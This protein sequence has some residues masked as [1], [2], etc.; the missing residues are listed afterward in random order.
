MTEETTS[1]ENANT[2]TLEADVRALQKRLEQREELLRVLN[3]RL[4]ELERGDTGPSGADHAGGGNL[5]LEIWDLNDQLD[6]LRAT[7][8]FRW[9]TP[10]RDVYSKLRRPR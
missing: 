7:K 8:L 1:L 9:S 4:L 5:Q 2:R 3:R 6:R 10:A